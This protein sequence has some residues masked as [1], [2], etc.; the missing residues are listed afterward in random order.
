MAT[1]PILSRFDRM[2]QQHQ[3]AD[4]RHADILLICTIAAGGGDITFSSLVAAALS[5]LPFVNLSVVCVAQ[6]SRDPTSAATFLLP[7]LPPGV[8]L[9]G[10]FSRGASNSVAPAPLPGGAPPPPAPPPFTAVVQG[11]LHL[12]DGA[13]EALVGLGLPRG[14][15][16]PAF[17]CL[18]EYGQ[19]RFLPPSAPPRVVHACGGLSFGEWGLWASPVPLAAALAA[20]RPGTFVGHF[21][22][23]AHGAQLGRLVAS[24]LLLASAEGGAAAEGA[25]EAVVVAPEGSHGALLE[26]LAGHPGVARMEGGG[27]PRLLLAPAAAGAQPLPLRVEAAPLLPRPQFL[28][29]LAGCDGAL[30]TG[31]ASLGEA[32]AFSAR[33]GLPFLYS[34]EGHKIFLAEALAA[35]TGAAPLVRRFWAFC[36]GGGGSG[37][38]APAEWAALL[39][40]LQSG[41]EPPLRALRGAFRAWGA[42]LLRERGTLGARLSAW[43]AAVAASPQ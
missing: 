18:R 41:G 1:S 12:F 22:T 24:V 34:V 19:Q 14:A 21:R 37:G 39:E 36:E 4:K 13:E 17:L 32:L 16:A 9:L 33:S 10:T 6:A 15:A 43:A 38:G 26:G 8:P 27:G 11:P 3:C 7:L 31:D 23:A 35:S 29:A 25:R 2:R 28:E 42:A 40:E 5:S 30:V 20:P